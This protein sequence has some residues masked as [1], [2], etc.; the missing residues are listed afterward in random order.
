MVNCKAAKY[1]LSSLI[2][3]PLLAMRPASIAAELFRSLR[4]CQSAARSLHG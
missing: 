3:R 4:N 1:T 2:A